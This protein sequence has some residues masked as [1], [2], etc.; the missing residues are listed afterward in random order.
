MKS[1]DQ[2]LKIAEGH[3]KSQGATAFYAGAMSGI[4]RVK[5]SLK[6]LYTKAG[7]EELFW[8]RKI[9]KENDDV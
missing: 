5:N 6:N 4:P 7:Y 3:A 1:G 2:L 8:S 9:L